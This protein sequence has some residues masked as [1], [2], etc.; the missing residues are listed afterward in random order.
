MLDDSDW[1]PRSRPKFAGWPLQIAI[2][3]FCSAIVLIVAYR[4]YQQ[5]LSRTRSDEQRLCEQRSQKIASAISYS[6]RER[7]VRA[8]GLMH[9]IALNPKV[10]DNEFSSFS[11]M[12]LKADPGIRSTGLVQGTVIRAVFPVEDNLDAVG[13]DLLQVPGQAAAVR[14]MME[15]GRPVL[16]GPLDLLEGGRAFVFRVPVMLPG[17]DDSTGDSADSVA[18]T[19]DQDASQDTNET[20]VAAEYWGHV[21]LVVDFESLISELTTDFPADLQISLQQ[22]NQGGSE[23]AFLRGEPISKAAACVEQPINLLGLTWRLSLIPRT[24]WAGRL[25]DHNVRV[26]AAAVLSAFSA[27][28]AWLIL[29]YH[30]LRTEHLEQLESAQQSM[31]YA[32]ARL[33]LALIRGNIGL[34]DLH[35]ISG[36]TI[37]SS[38]YRSMLRDSVTA[39]WSN[40]LDD[41][42]S[43]L[44]LDDKATACSTLSEFLEGDETHYYSEYRL[45]CGDGRY[46]WFRTEATGTGERGTKNHHVMGVL[47]DVSKDRESR[48][49]LQDERLETQLIL[50]SIPSLVILRDANDRIL[51]VNEAVIRATGID[52][53]SLSGKMVQE[54]LP[55][56][57][58]PRGDQPGGNQKDGIV[59]SSDLS[60]NDV[61]LL[62]DRWVQ[63][64]SVPIRNSRGWTDRTIIVSTD[65][66]DFRRAE[67]SQKQGSR[68]QTKVGELARIGGWDLDLVTNELTWSDMVKQIHEVPADYRPDVTTAI[69]FYR[70]DAR[71]SIQLL[72]DRAIADDSPWDVKLPL[73]TAKGRQIFVRCMGQPVFENGRCV[74]VWGVFQDVTKLH[75]ES[76][77][78]EALFRNAPNAYFLFSE[79]GILECNAPAIK[80]LRAESKEQIL[81]HHP[82]EFSPDRQPCGMLSSEKCKVI[83]ALARERGVHRFEWLHRRMD[84]EVFPCEVT[85][86][87]VEMDS[88]PALLAAWRDLS[89][90]KAAEGERDSFFALSFDLFCVIDES[91]KFKR[92][93]SAWCQVQGADPDHLPGV[94]VADLAIDGHRLATEKMLQELTKLGRVTEF[95]N[96][97]K[98]KDGT[99]HWLE[100]NALASTNDD[101]VFFA[102]AR[103]VTERIQS[104]Q[105]LGLLNDELQET[106]EALQQS[107]VDLQ[108]FAYVASHD[109]QTPLRGIAGF[110]Q[111]LVEDYSEQ[112]DDTASDYLSRIT[113]GTQRMQRLIQ[114]LL[115][116][117]RIEIQGQQL[118]P[119]QLNQVVDDILVLLQPEI[120]ERNT[121]ITRDQ[122]PTILGDASQL[123]QLFTNVI[124][125]GIKYNTS[126]VPEVA[127]QVEKCDDSQ[128]G[129]GKGWVEI[130][131]KDN[132]IGIEPEFQGQIFEVFRRL[133]TERQYSGTGIGL[134]ICK[135]V[136]QR[137]EG[138]IWVSGK[139]GEGSCF[140]L[141]FS[142]YTPEL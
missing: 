74:A 100:W 56:G 136:M 58:Q 41:W 44:H 36:Q 47:I 9:L 106:N 110:A 93:N 97:V 20:T 118:K 21:A 46:R 109:L 52:R 111:L 141:R 75:Q 101:K 54:V 50:D 60:S 86:S 24:G 68:F 45:R 84:G 139:P 116:Y 34:W 94:S 64:Q 7:M 69:Q 27:F 129:A 32:Q 120:D 71:E 2:P 26:L 72:I 115:Q 135:R 37:Y 99:D 126:K 63:T 13:T 49:R 31:Q 35:T 8:D 25:P 61:Q 29:R 81:A 77:L 130:T 121:R 78:R 138:E 123:F 48:E 91:G 128:Q 85:L 92:V 59:N 40:T 95:R 5:Q 30:L 89:D 15:T 140:H 43:R 88:A 103:D 104:E 39:A 16:D 11:S 132:G 53:E 19:V 102:V 114:D 33:Q 76:E 70:D 134:A 57:G 6:V 18:G 51:R 131:I 22:L 38:T 113:S 96:K 105:Q 23:V 12:L 66:T 142:E 107:N 137:H 117:S 98:W 14:A 127:I 124:G 73:M 1:Q 82:A 79:D 62:G 119:I 10:T 122:L 55:G 108:Q 87:Q 112:L 125:N 28:I 67:L 42:E 83:D 80:M 65:I 90:E 133:H 17:T 3:L 4:I